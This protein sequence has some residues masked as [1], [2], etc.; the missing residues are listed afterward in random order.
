MGNPIQ[1]LN[2]LRQGIGEAADKALG[3]LRKRWAAAGKPDYEAPLAEWLRPARDGE[4]Q[5]YRKRF[6]ELAAKA[7]RTRDDH[8]ALGEVIHALAAYGDNPLVANKRKVLEVYTPR[9]ALLR[10]WIGWA[11]AVIVVIW[12]QSAPLVAIAKP[13]ADSMADSAATDP[14]I[15]ALEDKLNDALAKVAAEHDLMVNAKASAD[16]AAEV[17]MAEKDRADALAKV[18][19]VAHATAAST[20]AAPPVATPAVDMWQ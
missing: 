2:A 15:K 6:D 4:H 17:A 3:E 14:Q 19:R 12:P 16:N 13:V 8:L 9:T 18:V 5:A 11:A 10:G 7:N 20:S 1:A